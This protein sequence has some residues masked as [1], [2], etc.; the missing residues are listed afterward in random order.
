MARR[1]PSLPAGQIITILMTIAALIGILVLKRQC[2]AAVGNMF[3]VIDTRGD[4]GSDGGLT[5][6]DT[7]RK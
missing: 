7:A 1:S 2:G 6:P 4:G 3:Q 5:S